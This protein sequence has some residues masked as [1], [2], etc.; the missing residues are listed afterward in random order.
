M[1]L[2][3]FTFRWLALLPSL[4]EANDCD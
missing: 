1:T 4:P 3:C 2:A